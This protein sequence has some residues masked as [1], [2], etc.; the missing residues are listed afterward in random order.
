MQAKQPESLETYAGLIDRIKAEYSDLTPQFQAGAKYLL[1]H[2]DEVII[3]SMRTIARNADVQSS[4]LVRLA[5]HFG[6]R[7]WPEL[8]AVFAERVRSVPEGYA[9]KAQSITRQKKSGSLIAEVFK[10]Q[11][12]NLDATETRNQAALLSVAKLIES[13]KQVHIAGFRASYPIAF[14]F[15]YLYRLFR[16]NVQLIDGHAGTLEMA[17]RAIGKDDGVVVIGFA[18]YSAEALIVARQARRIGCKLVAITDSDVAPIALEADESIVIAVESPS[19]FPS[20]VAGIAAVESLVELLV[21][22][23]GSTAVQRIEAAEK[24]LFETG[25]YLQSRRQ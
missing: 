12:I 14:S 23:G 10:S 24:Q 21:S 5:Q 8:K 7:G 19:F 25:A 9:K 22:R 13:T 1:D 11:R 3:S 6:F 15:Q 20:T 16:S 2:P 17:L 4:T 18:P